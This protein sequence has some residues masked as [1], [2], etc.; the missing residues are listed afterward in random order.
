MDSDDK[1]LSQ[2]TQTVPIS[3]DIILYTSLP[4][5][6]PTSKKTL[7]DNGG[8]I[9][10]I[11]T[12]SYSSAD[13]PTF[14]ISINADVTG[15]ISIGMRIKLTQITVKY[16]IVT[17]VGSYSAG[18]TL[19]TVYGGTDYTLANAAITTPYYSQTK[20]PLG[21]PLS[22]IKWTVS[23]ITTDS[24]AKSSPTNATWYGGGGLTPTGP[25]INLPIGSWKVSYRVVADYV[26]NIASVSII[27]CRVTLSTANNSESDAEFTTSISNSLPISTT[28]TQRGVYMA[29]KNI[30]VA[31]KTTYYLNI[32]TGNATGTSP[33]LVMNPGGVFKNIIKAVCA[34]L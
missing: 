3:T 29:E 16:F 24:P 19:V 33:S 1:K 26:T 11:G 23:T 34:Y 27:G 17:E 10:G 21:F 12:W 6:A 18:A 7:Y 15:Y 4:A 20:A 30:L 25:S 9:G 28:A 22:P 13:S 8:W 2:L 5:T 32:Y 31:S 14:V